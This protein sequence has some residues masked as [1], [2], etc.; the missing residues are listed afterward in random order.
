MQFKNTF[1]RPTA[2]DAK[3][4]PWTA[5]SWLYIQLQLQET[6]PR[7]SAGPEVAGV[8]GAM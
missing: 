1:K 6:Q 2:V 8:E 3:S 7:A 4:G 5:P